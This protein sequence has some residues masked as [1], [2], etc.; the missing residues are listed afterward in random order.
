MNNR[1]VFYLLLL[2][3]TLNPVK[4]DCRPVEEGQETTLTCT[5]NTATLSCPSAI[6]LIWKKAD[7]GIVAVCESHQ[8]SNYLN[9]DSF[10]ATISKRGSTLA[11]TN[12]SRIDPFNMEDKWTCRLCGD[13]KKE[14][15]ACD[16]L[17]VY[18]KPEK[19]SCTVR[20]NKDGSDDIESVTVS[21]STINVYPTAKC[22][23]K[24]RKNGGKFITINK[25][26]TYNH[27]QTTGSL[28]YYWSEC[29][30]DVPVEELGEGTHSFSTFIYPD[31]TDGIDLVDETA[32]SNTV[33]LTLPKTSIT[34]STEII[35]GYIK[36][37]ST[38]CT[39]VLT[40][41]GYP[42]GQAQWYRGSQVVPGVSDIL[43]SIFDIN[44][45]VQNFDCKARSTIGESSR[46]KLTVQYAFF[47]ENAV[48]MK[49]STSIIDQCNDT[50]YANNRHPIICR[51]LKDKIYPAPIFSVSLDGRTFDVPRE[52]YNST[53]F[54]QSQFYPTPNIGGVYPITCRVIN[55]ITDKTQEQKIS[56]T[57]RKP[58]LLPPKI[59]IKGKTYQ[60]VNARNRITLAAGHT[61]D[62]SCQVEGGYPIAN[63]T[64]LTCGSL[65]ASGGGNV[66]T[67]TI[68]K[69]QL[70]EE[71][72]GTECK[73][74]SHHVTGCYNNNET[75]LEL[76]VTSTARSEDSLVN[77][78]TKALLLAY[79]CQFF[80]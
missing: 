3:S 32:A 44:N 76:Y 52:G 47:E 45:P 26:P 22:S 68:Q 28:V 77:V 30:V 57:F 39:C 21:C 17:E 7:T 15:T 35:H 13:D 20:E 63:T 34:C 79:L 6:A 50:N 59:T 56:V 2:L 62:I 60:G 53:M 5:I 74:T 69:N 58:P 8:C 67:L 16:K 38:K 54:Y 24:R 64:Q 9:S 78:I 18:A 27:T 1:G 73:C 61:E 19:P 72:N 14:I 36:G 42:K 66:A 65:T 51:V 48:S 55:K 29:S 25:S 33:T 43:E 41:D 11:I 31:V 49:S 80:W 75:F 37:K 23:F 70:N 10:S 12:V 4:S 40:S 46:S 71:M